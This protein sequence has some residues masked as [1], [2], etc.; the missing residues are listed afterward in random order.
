ML[1]CVWLQE[2][3]FSLSLTYSLWQCNTKVWIMLFFIFEIIWVHNGAERWVRCR[4]SWLASKVVSSSKLSYFHIITVIIIISIITIILYLE[5]LDFS[6][7]SLKARKKHLINTKLCFWGINRIPTFTPSL[8]QLKIK[9][10]VLCSLPFFNSTLEKVP[11]QGT[12]WAVSAHLRA[13]C[14]YLIGAKLKGN[15]IQVLIGLVTPPPPNRCC[16]ITAL[17]V[18]I[19]YHAYIAEGKSSSQSSCSQQTHLIC[20]FNRERRH[21]TRHALHYTE[22]QTRIFVSVTVKEKVFWGKVRK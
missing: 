4:F 15:P 22:P 6:L 14:C 20:F 18:D 21:C 10:K 16:L 7:F 3:C 5:Y 19:I 17:I 8:I 1:L 13:G 11:H 2:E 12:V 9:R